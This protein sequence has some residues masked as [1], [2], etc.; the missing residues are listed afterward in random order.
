MKPC[1][2]PL[3][4]CL[5][6]TASLAAEPVPALDRFSVAV[7]TFSNRLDIDGRIDGSAEFDG[8]R[9]DFDET[10]NVGNRRRIGLYE[11]AWRFA[12]HHQIE[13]RRYRDSRSRTARL[14]ETLRFNGETFPIQASLRGSAGFELTEAIYTYW[15]R[16]DGE[17]PFGLQFGALR[18]KGELALR[19]RIAVEGEG[20][21]EGESAVSAR[22]DAPLIGIA[23]R[24][25]IGER[26]RIFG[27]ARLIRLHIG[28][29]EGHAYSG[30]LGVEY[31]PLEHLGLTLQYSGARV[32]AEQ[33]KD[34]LAGE[35][36][37]GFAG[38]QLLARWRF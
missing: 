5:V 27:E 32:A 21:A 26:W 31:F 3:A 15:F 17:S 38:P 14:D 24:R 2:L 29:V 30:R 35:L 11:A 12:E 7:G 8:S 25:V 22:I 18:L 10:L 20:E 1:L 23:G 28:D 34:E 16:P 4:G 37:V 33:R 19:G 6:A 36:E 13:L 9:R